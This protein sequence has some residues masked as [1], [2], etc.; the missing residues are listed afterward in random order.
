[1]PPDGARASVPRP[2]L[3]RSNDGRARFMTP[4]QAG[5]DGVETFSLEGRTALVVGASRGIGLAIARGLA[6]A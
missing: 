2:M 4:G 3:L 6:A 5:V 1:M